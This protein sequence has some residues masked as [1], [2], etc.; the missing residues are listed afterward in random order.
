[1]NASKKEAINNEMFKQI[2]GNNEPMSDWQRITIETDEKNP[3]IVAQVTSNNFEIA[4]GY[5]VRLTPVYDD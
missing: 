5:R 1:M 2:E 4:N 3:K